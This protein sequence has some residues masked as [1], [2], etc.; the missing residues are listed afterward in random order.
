MKVYLLGFM[1]VG[2]TTYGKKTAY[3]L[4][5][6]FIDLDKYIEDKYKFTVS[7]FFSA[8]DENAFRVVE[9]NCL[10]EISE[11]DNLVISTGGGTPVYYNN[12]EII[13]STGLSIYLK[14]SP[15]QLL[16]RLSKSKR[17]RPLIEKKSETE[18]LNYITDTLSKREIYYDSAD[19]TIDAM[20]LKTWDLI[21]I[22]KRHNS[23]T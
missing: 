23:T 9:H 15:T 1:G 18:L 11:L 16:Q 20:N 13:K 12:L 19:Y 17:K 8:L 22:I 5:Y 4:N 3:K 14:L 7:S 2:K 6:K 10:K 21:E